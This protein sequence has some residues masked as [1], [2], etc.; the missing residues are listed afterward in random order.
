MRKVVYRFNMNSAWNFI[1]FVITFL[2]QAIDKDADDQDEILFELVNET[3]SFSITKQ[4]VLSVKKTPLTKTDTGFLMIMAYNS[5]SYSNSSLSSKTQKISVKVQVYN[6]KISQSIAEHCTSQS[7]FRYLTQTVHPKTLNTLRPSLTLDIYIV[8][9]LHVHWTLYITA[10]AQLLF[11]GVHL[12]QSS[13]II[14]VVTPAFWV[15]CTMYSVNLRT[16]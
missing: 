5:R 1:Y 7:T 4:G 6:I 3:S 12:S 14:K 11:Q 2:L 15:Q 13:G 9:L 16:V 8:Q 10:K